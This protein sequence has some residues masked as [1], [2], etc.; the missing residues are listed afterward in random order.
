MKTETDLSIC[1]RPTIPHGVPTEK[2]PRLYT[3]QPHFALLASG[4]NATCSAQTEHHTLTHTLVAAL[5]PLISLSFTALFTQS[6]HF[7]HTNTM[8]KMFEKTFNCK[9]AWMI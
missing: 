6:I 2:T 3:H 9:N 5:V 4:S 7:R 1:T 8:R